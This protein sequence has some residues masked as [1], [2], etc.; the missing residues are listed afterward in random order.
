VSGKKNDYK[1]PPSETGKKK[2]IEENRVTKPGP[3]NG[4]GKVDPVGKGISA[5]PY[6]VKQNHKKK[7]LTEGT[8]KDFGCAKRDTR[9]KGAGRLGRSRVLAQGKQE[10]GTSPAPGGK[11]R[12]GKVQKICVST[13]GL[14]C[15]KGSKSQCG[16][17]GL[18]EEG[19]CHLPEKE[20]KK[21]VIGLG[22]S[23]EI[24]FSTRLGVKNRLRQDG[25]ENVKPRGGEGERVTKRLKHDESLA[26][27]RIGRAEQKKRT[28][29]KSRRPNSRKHCKTSRLQNSGLR[30]TKL[31]EG[32]NN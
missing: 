12:T 5:R 13:S 26:A 21:W 10:M 4:P 25:E 27:S 8:K 29:E 22:A 19:T 6:K 7:D 30:S 2:K 24:P 1:I 3:H 23:Q 28:V 16:Q 20:K 11:L 14:W 9:K 18:G 31:T 15:R 32:K 17:I